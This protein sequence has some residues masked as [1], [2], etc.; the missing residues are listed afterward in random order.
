MTMTPNTSVA[1]MIGALSTTVSG[2][3]YQIFDELALVMAV[4]GGMG[5][6]CRAVAIKGTPWREVLRSVFLGSLLAF[7]VGVFSP[8]IVSRMLGI[9]ITGLDDILPLL[10]ASSFLIGLLQDIFMA[11]LRKGPKDE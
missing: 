11:W 9:D 1:I 6:L 2:P 3:L 4:L 8:A 5:G 10:A 7:G